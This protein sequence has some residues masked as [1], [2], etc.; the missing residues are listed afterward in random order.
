MHAT[1]IRPK[2]MLKRSSFFLGLILLVPV[3]ASAQTFTNEFNRLRVLPE[4]STYIANVALADYNG[5]GRLDIYHAGRL[6]RQEDDGSFSNVL[7]QA[8]INLEG[9]NVQGGIFADA[10]RDGRLDL[11]IMDSAPGSRFYMN[12]TG[13]KFD[14][15]NSTTNLTFQTGIRGA[16]WW[17]VNLDGRLD[18]VAAAANG[19]HPVYL[20]NESGTY[21]N[22][23]DPWRAATNLPTAGLAVAD[24]DRDGDPDF[25]SAHFAGQNFLMENNAARDRFGNASSF[26]GVNSG[27]VAAGAVW[28]DYD[29]DGWQD[30][31]VHNLPQEFNTSENHLFHNDQGVF[32]DRAAEAGILGVNPTPNTPAA[33]ADFDND[34]WEDIY[35][36]IN[37]RGRLFHNNGDGT[38]DQR[39]ATTVA[40]DSVSASVAVGDVNNDGWLDI[41]IPHQLGTAI[42]INDGG[43]NNWATFALRGDENNRFGV[44]ATVRVTSGGIQQMR[45]VTAGTGMGNQSDGLRAHF[46]IG[47]N[48]QIDEL[49]IEWTDG[50]VEVYTDVDPNRHYT[51]VKNVGPNDPPGGFAQTFPLNAGFV[52]PADPMLR[53]EWEE[54]S[55]EDAVLYTVHIVG[56]GVKLTFPNLTDPFLDLETVFLPANQIY[57]W[58]VSSTDGYSVRGTGG[59]Y[60]FSFGQPDVANSTLQDPALFDFGIPNM[61]SG[62]AAFADYDVDGDLDLLV[63]GDADGTAIVRLFRANDASVV[64]SNNG[65]EFIF[66]SLEE[67]G[68]TLELVREPDAAWGDFDNDGDPDL[69]ITGLLV[70]TGEPSTTIYI[71]NVGTFIPV[72]AEGILDVWGGSAEWG[73]VNGDGLMDLL[74]SGATN[75]VQPYEPI[76]DVFINNNNQSYVRADAGLPGVAFGEAA[77]ADIDGDGDLDVALTGDRGNGDFHSGIYINNG[78][79]TGG[80][81]SLDGTQLPELVGG[82]VTWGDVDADNEPDLLITGGKLGPRMLAGITE[83]YVNDS[84]IFSKHPFPFDGVVTG[85]AIWGD[86]ENDG[87]ED[88]FVVGARSPL[89]ETVG[90]LYRNVDGQFAAELDVKGFVHA[91][92]AFG[93]YNQDGDMDLIAFGIDSQGNNSVTFYIN[94]QVPEPVPVTR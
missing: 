87:D 22:V 45:S 23:G 78:I 7:S 64:L 31:L 52:D 70:E 10:N 69:V 89:G 86:Y 84:G 14:L 13:E 40:L 29:N 59:E 30:L 93:D 92:A 58:S 75:K 90:R 34:G 20:A 6:Y 15:A 88:I 27:R 54:S 33:V 42:M 16:F 62:M 5:D 17:D 49:R 38:F 2:S 56:P 73:D 94:Q 80:T 50:V 46:G 19:D 71:N 83:M 74:L 8:D 61:S 12:R 41:V 18:M 24:Y 66:K 55:D 44:G 63:A 60:S 67:T 35:L 39:W 48:T 21:T 82:S 47:Q 28:L 36:P 76:T 26:R 51:M 91:T 53:F 81:F 72:V 65:G 25:Y 9:N 57:T 68:V 32:S 77:W 85:R 3:S 43:G 4:T 1:L 79:A 37:N 11:L